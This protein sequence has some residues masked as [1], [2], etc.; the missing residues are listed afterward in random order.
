MWVQNE[1]GTYQL[2]PH[3]QQL[4]DALLSGNYK[5]GKEKLTTVVDG[6]DYDCCLGVACKIAGEPSEIQARIG[7]KGETKLVKRYGY[8][9]DTNYLTGP[10]SEY[11]GFKHNR[12]M[13][14]KEDG[15]ATSVGGYYSLTQHN[16]NNKT[17]PEIASLIKE[18]APLL[19]IDPM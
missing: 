14:M 11:F 9:D 7:P 2:G 13:F 15:F 19:F 1:D 17:F 3:Q 6:V 10:A 5:Q 4:V 16:D 12:A 18:N 8:K